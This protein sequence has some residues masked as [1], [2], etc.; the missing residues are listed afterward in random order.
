MAGFLIACGAGRRMRDSAG[1]LMARA[2]RT[3]AVLTGVNS[4]GMQPEIASRWFNAF[5]GGLRT[6]SEDSD[7][8]VAGL[9]LLGLTA[10]GVAD[11][12]KNDAAKTILTVFDR[13][14]KSPEAATAALKL[15]GK[16]WWDETLRAKSAGT[17][18]RKQLDFLKDSKN[19]AG[20]LDK[21]LNVQL[22]TTE[23]HLKRLGALSS[24][25]GDTL[26]RWALPGI[27]EKIEGAIKMVDEFERRW[28]VMK[29]GQED[30]DKT[31]STGEFV[32]AMTEGAKSLPGK[33]LDH[34][35]APL[36]TNDPAAK[37]AAQNMEEVRDKTA[38]AAK[39]RAEAAILET[40]ALKATKKDKAN[41]LARAKGLRGEAASSDDQAD[42]A[43]RAAGAAGGRD[44]TNV[45]V[46]DAAAKLA[47]Q[48]MRRE[49]G[50]E[51][52]L[53][54]GKGA[55]VGIPGTGVVM[56]RK[57]AEQE[58]AE[59]RAKR[60]AATK[61]LIETTTPG[62]LKERA[63]P[64][65]PAR[66]A[67]LAKPQVD[68]TEIEKAK[69]TATAAGEVMKV[70]L[71][72]SYHPLVDI[73]SITA[74]IAAAQLL[75]ATLAGLG[76]AGAGVARAAASTTAGRAVA[77]AGRPSG[78]STAPGPVTTALRRDMAP[79][80]QVA[81]MGN[82]QQAARGR[83]INNQGGPVTVNVAQ[84]NASPKEIGREVRKGT[85]QD[86]GWSVNANEGFA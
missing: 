71:G 26:G 86:I 11:G 27:N 78:G 35:I 23:N 32:T 2:A 51:A 76:N 47:I 81:K 13:L 31:D 8:T 56:A 85:S 45:E 1:C 19:Y 39:Q 68:T 29:A 70:S 75:K 4:A 80:V 44:L 9:K 46:G 14:E 22:G 40:Q 73:A 42:M 38:L 66:P 36:P 63:V 41:L 17:E 58:L 20:S 83:T 37:Q 67:E 5:A 10:K 24:S 54:K 74:A 69:A 57:A 72:G 33:A 52:A 59:I 7:E 3:L 77:A 50:L 62:E 84:T 48:K 16:G 79:S 82:A 64:Q 6:A 30:S 18:I 21:G 15:F 49:R 25:V 60:D 34:L 53:A 28:K 61:G 12:M 65:P 55:N 43:K